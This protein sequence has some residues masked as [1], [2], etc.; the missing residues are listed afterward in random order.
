VRKVVEGEQHEEPEDL[1]VDWY[2]VLATSLGRQIQ[3][4]Y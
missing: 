1:A 3:D 2:F 4:V